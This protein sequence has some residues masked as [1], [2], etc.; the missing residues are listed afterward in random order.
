MS[1]TGKLCFTIITLSTARVVDMALSRQSTGTVYDLMPQSAHASASRLF[2]RKKRNKRIP[3]V[4]G[5][6]SGAS[7]LSIPF[8]GMRFCLKSILSKTNEYPQKAIGTMSRKSTRRMPG[9]SVLSTTHVVALALS[10]QSTGTVCDLMPQSAH[11]TLRPLQS[12]QALKIFVFFLLIFEERIAQGDDGTSEDDAA[13]RTPSP[14]GMMSAPTTA[15]KN[16]I[17]KV[18]KK[19]RQGRR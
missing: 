4:P 6:S 10:R 11:T 3:P 2:S 18:R 8:V 13:R 12:I 16:S 19:T 9:S 7:S 1:S 14:Q 17:F 15:T 5:F